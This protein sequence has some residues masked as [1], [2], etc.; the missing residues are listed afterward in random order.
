MGSSPTSDTILLEGLMII[1]ESQ[2]TRGLTFCTSFT[3]E[4]IQTELMF[5]DADPNF[6]Y[7]K[8]GPITKAFIDAIVADN[9]VDEP[10]IF[11]SRTHRLEPGWYPAIPGW[12]H[13]DASR[14]NNINRRPEY[15]NPDYRS[16]H[17]M[18]LV[19]GDIAPTE[20]ALGAV[21]FEI[22][23]GDYVYGIWGPLVDKAIENNEL[24]LIRA[25]SNQLI[26]FNDRVWHRASM[27]VKSGWRWWGRMSYSTHRVV[28]NKIMDKYPTYK[29]SEN[30][31]LVNV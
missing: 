30:G 17:C 12:H 28:T 13:E 19:N 25:P 1:L 27:A 24:D 10:F 31:V 26:W 20:F 5:M 4:Q 18:G 15:I 7:D 16:F 2:I 9:F 11:D 22:P 14:V 3:E 21:D 23:Q 8:G 29:I 6:A